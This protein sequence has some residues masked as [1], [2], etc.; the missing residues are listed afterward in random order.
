MKT[1]KVKRDE[2]LEQ[3]R[4]NRT[5][6]RAVFEK[7]LEGYRKAVIKRLTEMLEDA[8][9]GK[10]VEQV[11]LLMQP[12]NQTA[13]YD[14]VIKMLEMSVQDEIELTSQDFGCYVMDRWAWKSQF[15]LSSSGYITEGDLP[16]E[17]IRTAFGGEE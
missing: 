15:A 2:L 17:T 3:I 10:R 13:E 11:T 8:K 16:A 9:G 7:A 14:Q 1:V 5:A 6:H 12:T 4:K